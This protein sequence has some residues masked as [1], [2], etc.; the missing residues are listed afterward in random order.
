[1]LFSIPLLGFGKKDTTYY[2]GVNGKI[3]D[4]V[5]KVIMQSVEY[6]G[7]TRISIKTFKSTGEGWQQMV[8]ENI[9]IVSDSVYQI[10][11][12]GE[13]FS[14]KV[15]RTFQT[16]ENGHFKFTDKVKNRIK[17]V[18]FST[19]KVPVILDGEVTDYYENG[20][21]RSVAQYKN[22]ELISN[23]NWLPDGTQIV[24]DIFYSVDSE[25]RFEPGMA[26]IHQQIS[27]AIN[28]AKFDLSTVQGRM[29]VGLVITKEGEI[30]GVRI[31]DGISQTLNG[32]LV[33]AF[34]NIKGA[35]IPAKLNGEDVNY[36]QLFPI[37]FIYNQYNFDSLEFNSGILFWE[38]N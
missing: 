35:W 32:I 2:Y 18:G 14:G 4:P 11:I 15:I 6:R 12:K 25:P 37:N 33:N 20:D 26:F 10:R 19:Q 31:V 30:G 7:K 21:K 28:Q 24:D 22:N 17:R 9:K 36:F 16:A 23:K 29:I 34:E 1:M 27:Q 38:I 8:T 3:K 13:N 5:E